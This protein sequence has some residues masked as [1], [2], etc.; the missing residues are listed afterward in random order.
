M[1]LIDIDRLKLI[2]NHI[3]YIKEYEGSCVLMDKMAK[4]ARNDIKFSIEYKP[5]GA[6]DI[7]V[8][9]LGDVAFPVDALIPKVKERIQKMDHDGTLANLHKK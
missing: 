5:M 4:I 7:K 2:E 6:P 9:F 1:K 8:N 3:H